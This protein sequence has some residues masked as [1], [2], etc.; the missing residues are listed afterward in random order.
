MRAHDVT[1]GL[2]EFS[3]KTRAQ[4]ESD[5]ISASAFAFLYRS[6][7]SPVTSGYSVDFSALSD[8]VNASGCQSPLRSTP[9]P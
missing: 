9:S 7:W 3:T 6:D 5:I 4:L 2:S 1:V 8:T